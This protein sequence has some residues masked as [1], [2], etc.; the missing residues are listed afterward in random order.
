MADIYNHKLAQV[1]RNIFTVTG[2]N[3]NEYKLRLQAPVLANDMK[4]AGSIVIVNFLGSGFSTGSLSCSTSVNEGDALAV[5]VSITNIPLTTALTW[6]VNIISGLTTNDFIE[7]K[8]SVQ[9]RTDTSANFQVTVRRDK[10]TS[11]GKQFTISLLKGG[12][13]LDTSPTISVVDVSQTPA[14][15]VTLQANANEGVSVPVT[16]T[17]IPSAGDSPE[18]TQTLAWSLVSNG[19]YA[20][21]SNYTPT[22]GT[23]TLSN[24]TGSFNVST[25]ADL[26][27]N[28]TTKSF[29]IKLSNLNGTSVTQSTNPTCTIA[30]TSR[31]SWAG[32]S[33]SLAGIPDNIHQVSTVASSSAQPYIVFYPNGTILARGNGFTQTNWWS[34][35]DPTV[36]PNFRVKFDYTEV[37]RTANGTYIE[38]PAASGTILQLNQARQ[39]FF[40]AESFACSDPNTPILVNRNGT[41]KLAGE[42]IAGDQ[43]YTMHEATRDWGYYSVTHAEIVTQ[44][45]AVVTFDDGSILHVSL[46]HKFYL[47]KNIWRNLFN[48]AVGDQVATYT[49]GVKR[50]IT[51]IEQTGPGPVVSLEVEDAH[52]YIANN[53]I[54][55][56][57]KASV[58]YSGNYL[59]RVT[60]NITATI[61]G[62]PNYNVAL[63]TKTFQLKAEVSQYIPELDYSSYWSGFGWGAG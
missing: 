10:L 15:S 37:T 44:P 42:L 20:A 23:V 5:T 21:G 35:T 59:T 36:G 49:S 62:P 29:N 57:N 58:D 16:I 32:G 22:S 46:S 45:K 18:T 47:G 43:V 51:S 41:T 34:V 38:V 31:E 13:V 52:T 14:F 50:T 24:G 26:K 19:G 8:G 27:T 1:K 17:E 54:S 55:H 6:R 12:D 48:L 25:I 40:L 63:A 11:P 7:T 56:N 4:H 61:Y 3:T 53:I 2:N 28:Y 33:A 60:F 30:D 39:I 9:N